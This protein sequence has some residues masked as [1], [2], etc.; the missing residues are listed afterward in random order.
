HVICPDCGN[1]FEV[2]DYRKDTKCPECKRE[3]NPDKDGNV[4]GQYY[5]CPECGQKSKIVETIQRRGKPA[6]KIYA[7][8]YYCPSCNQKGYRQADE[9]DV[10]LFEKAKEE[11]IKVEP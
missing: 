1:L 5:I 11:Y 10:A 9:F 3:F 4:E 2:E 7:V 6:E 8:E